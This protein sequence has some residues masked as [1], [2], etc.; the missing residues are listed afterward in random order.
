MNHPR[1]S[2]ANL[3]Y[4]SKQFENNFEKRFANSQCHTMSKYKAFT[5]PTFKYGINR[6]RYGPNWYFLCQYFTGSTNFELEIFNQWKGLRWVQFCSWKPTKNASMHQPLTSTYPRMQL[7]FFQ[8]W[9]ICGLFSSFFKM[10]EN[11]GTMLAAF[12][13]TFQMT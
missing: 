10:C 1:L 12:W 5:L 4:N 7:Y 11:N 13:Y 2:K 3:K 8:T 6:Y 9:I